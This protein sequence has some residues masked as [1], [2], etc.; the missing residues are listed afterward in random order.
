MMAD[1]PFEKAV[2]ESFRETPRPAPEDGPVP[3]T[4]DA[5]APRDGAGG[6]PWGRSASERDVSTATPGTGVP[7]VGRGLGRSASD[8]GSPLPERPLTLD[9]PG[10]RPE[11]VDDYVGDYPTGVPHWEKAR[12]DDGTGKPVTAGKDL[13][14]P[15][16]DY[17]NGV[18]RWDDRSGMRRPEPDRVRPDERRGMFDSGPK[19]A[20]LVYLMCLG[21]FLIPLLPLIAAGMAFVNRREASDDI[22][23]HY[24]Y[25][26]R[27][28]IG[29]LILGFLGGLV[30]LDMIP[31]YAVGVCAWYGLRCMRGLG[32]LGADLRIENPNTYWI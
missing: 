29:I 23:T 8:A 22:D 13:R 17:P 10:R 32:R 9:T 20:R 4:G 21:G 30:P 3:P 15:I 11:P 24:T 1:D 14:E 27:T 31:L 5:S 7:T 16:G 28:V 12:I 18:P 26:M 6:A 25:A 19:N 2:E